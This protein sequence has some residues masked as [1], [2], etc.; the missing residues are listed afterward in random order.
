LASVTKPLVAYATLVSIEEHSTTL[1]APVGPP[2]ATVR[3]LL[4]HASGLSPDDE[5]QV[6][7][8]PGERRIYSS[9]GFCALG[10]HLEE[11]TGFGLEEYLEGA[12]LSPLGMSTAGLPGEAGAGG[13][14]SVADLVAFVS[15]LLAPSL[16]SEGTVTLARSV[17]FPGLAG[18]LPGFGRQDPCD[19]GLGFEIRDH[20]VPH[21]T[22]AAN[23]P[24]T[25]GHF[26]QSGTFFWVD[27]AVDV[28]LV[29][30]TDRAFDGWAH[31][32][33]P[34]LSDAVLAAVTAQGG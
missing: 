27:P 6:L 18:V 31:V 17:A 22:G 1:D 32:A 7:A 5:T 24:A 13:L 30:L 14:A 3:H 8:Q 28:A 15:E 23:S 25:F 34:E 10:R 16:L 2:G 12:V 21:W 11:C 33:W 19:F 9:A 20:K 26:G 29:L 4:S